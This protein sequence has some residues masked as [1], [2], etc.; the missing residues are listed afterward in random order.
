MAQD[1]ASI[2]SCSTEGSHC[3][4]PST[5]APHT[6]VWLVYCP[7]PPPPVGRPSLGDRPPPEGETVARFGGR[8]QW[9]GG[10]YVITPSHTSTH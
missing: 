7:P 9:G 8:L 6:L 1:M 3:Q 4:N 2:V 10:G 5:V